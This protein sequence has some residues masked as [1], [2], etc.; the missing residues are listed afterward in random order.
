MQRVTEK[1]LLLSPPGGLF[2]MTA[3]SNFFPDSSEGAR[4]VLVHRAVSAGEVIRLKPGLFLLHAKYRKSDPHP[5]VVAALLHAPSHISLET[6][7]SYHGLIPEAVYQTASVTAARSRAFDT[8]IGR[9]TFQRVP[10]HNPRAGVLAVKLGHETWAFVAS[11]LRS[12]AD[13]VYL[14]PSVSWKK[15]GL[16]FLIDSLR[17][18]EENLARIELASLEEIQESLHSRRVGEYLEGLRKELVK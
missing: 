16:G 3:V 2:D 6:A 12:I 14:R 1:A 11:A 7:L 9:F 13:I 5:Y 8:L 17:I 10:C 15:D 4:K 18:E